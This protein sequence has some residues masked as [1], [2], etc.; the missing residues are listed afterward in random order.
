M[1]ESRPQ[2]RTT[3]AQGRREAGLGNF[4]DQRPGYIAFPF[5]VVVETGSVGG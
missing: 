3:W 5:K 4:H 2:G 1:A